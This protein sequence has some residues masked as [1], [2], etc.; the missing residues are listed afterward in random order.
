[1]GEPE[2]EFA[3]YIVYNLATKAAVDKVF[4]WNGPAEE[5]ENDILGGTVLL[6][7]HYDGMVNMW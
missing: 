5:V 3:E 2:I 7:I 6:L 1:L 4:R